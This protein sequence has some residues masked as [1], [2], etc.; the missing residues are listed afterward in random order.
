MAVPK[1][2]FPVLVIVA[3]PLNLYL[4]PSVAAFFIVHVTDDNLEPDGISHV[5]LSVNWSPSVN[6]NPVIDAFDVVL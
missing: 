6:D 4:F 1:T 3:V 5:K 2:S